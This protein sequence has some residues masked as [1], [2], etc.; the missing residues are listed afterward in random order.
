MTRCTPFIG[1]IS[2]KY[3]LFRAQVKTQFISIFLFIYSVSYASTGVIYCYFDPGLLITLLLL[4]SPTST[5]Y[6]KLLSSLL[7]PA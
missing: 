7:E 1:A 2:S 4:Y 3:S 5:I 6:N